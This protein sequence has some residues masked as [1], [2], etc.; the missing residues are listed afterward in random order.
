VKTVDQVDALADAV[1]QGPL[2]DREHSYLLDLA[3]L[4]AGRARLRR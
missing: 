2:S 3:D 4:D 1:A